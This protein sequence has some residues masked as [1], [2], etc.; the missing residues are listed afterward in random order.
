[1]SLAFN[2]RAYPKNQEVI[3]SLMKTRYEIATLLGYASWADYNAADKMIAKG[4]GIADFIK[5][6]NDSSRA[7]SQREFEMLLVEK[8]K[9][10]P[11]AKEIWD[12]ER[13]YLSELVRRTKYDF[14]SQSVRPY[15]P[16]MEVKQG[17][18]DTA[19][20]LFHVS[21]QQEQNVPPGIPPSKPG[22]SLTAASHR[23]LLSRHAP[24]SRQIQP[25]RNGPGTR[26]H[27][28]QTIA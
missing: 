15:F 5:E 3:T 12:Y 17:I 20:D 13:A 7:L 21:F 18:L 26:W 10:D 28:R 1:M 11:S 9:T 4:Q 25:C 14:D 2:T 16:F 27:P 8:Q 24:A 19:A 22:S 6:V 23:P